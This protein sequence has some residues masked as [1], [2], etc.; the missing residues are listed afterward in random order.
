[1]MNA[2]TCPTCHQWI[3]P[4]GIH[5]CQDISACQPRDWNAPPKPRKV[6]TTVREYDGDGNLVKETI[7]EE[8][9]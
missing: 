4:G 3:V 7:T 6:V 1:M 5:L 8:T 2:S 9:S